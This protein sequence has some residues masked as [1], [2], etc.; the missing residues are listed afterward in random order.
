MHTPIG[1]IHRTGVVCAPQ[2]WVTLHTD[3]ISTTAAHCWSV[4]LRCGSR[5]RTDTGF[6]IRYCWLSWSSGLL[7]FVCAAVA[8]HPQA[9]IRMS[10]Q[11]SSV[12]LASLSFST[13]QPQTRTDAVCPASS[14]PS[15][16]SGYRVPATAVSFGPQ[17]R[18][19]HIKSPKGLFLSQRQQAKRW[20]SGIGV[21]NGGPI[22][23]R[24]R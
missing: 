21:G 8:L 20:L 3:A 10:N 5:T 1:S 14:G 9:R 16:R 19:G 6:P 2:Q 23:V 13:L 22:F 12:G 7:S 4:L 17:D 18:K 15:S 11:S 24:S